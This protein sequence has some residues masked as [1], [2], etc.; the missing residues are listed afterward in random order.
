MAARRRSV[1]FAGV[2]M[3]RVIVN[4]AAGYWYPAGQR[5]LAASLHAIG[6]QATQL[7]YLGYPEGCPTHEQINY[8]FKVWALRQAQ[9]DG[10][11]QALWV[12]A[13]CWAIKPL[14]TVWW[15]LD[16]HGYYLEADGHRLGEWISA[17]A[18]EHLQVTRDQVWRWPLPTGAL[19]GID[20]RRPAGVRLLDELERN[21]D[22]FSGPWTND[23]FQASP[24]A[25]CKGHR[26][27]IAVCGV[28][29]GL[30]GLHVDPVK[31]VG[32]PADGVEPAA[33]VAL[34]AQGMADW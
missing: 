21:L 16:Q 18:L 7:F 1:L 20:F 8:G 15:L 26:H 29:A 4:V 11:D 30:L 31:A 33:S 32:F 12:D 19:I 10:Y 9:Q 17:A 2:D 24:D 28:L 22:A 14:D 6:E 5:R 23:G 13:S 34:L 27:D 25:R 3:R